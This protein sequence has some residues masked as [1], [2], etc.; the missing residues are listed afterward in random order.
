M[1]DAET[2]KQI[3]DAIGA[4]GAWKLKLTTAI[5]K[6]RSELSP[7]IVC[8]DDRCTFGQWL[9]G[10][11]LSPEI[12]SGKPYEVVK[13]LHAEFHVCAANVL[14]KAVAGDKPG[15]LALLE[16]EYADRS[17]ILVTALSKWKME[18]S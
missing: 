15:A 9:H 11:R 14:K 10:T 17:R 3:T 1:S 7:D 16:S 12:K 18:V 5:D 6:G 4:H 2:A 8:R 13:R